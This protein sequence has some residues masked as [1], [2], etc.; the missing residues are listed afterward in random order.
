MQKIPG[1]FWPASQQGRTHGRQAALEQPMRS[2][3]KAAYWRIKGMV[4][5]WS[6]QCHSSRGPM[7]TGPPATSGTQISNGGE[8]T[9]PATTTSHTS[10]PLHPDAT[11][12]LTP[13]NA[14]TAAAVTVWYAL[15][16]AEDME[17]F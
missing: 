1:Q 7:R 4:Q 11:N 9:V 13:L 8:A 14:D 3:L 12:M 17:L 6:S 10:A 16:F 2:R 5:T 15:N